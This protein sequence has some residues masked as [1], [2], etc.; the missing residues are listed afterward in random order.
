MVAFT[1]KIGGKAFKMATLSPRV[2]SDVTAGVQ[3]CHILAGHV[4]SGY[5]EHFLCAGSR[6]VSR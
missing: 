5:C 4:L 6:A 1:G 2:P 3:K